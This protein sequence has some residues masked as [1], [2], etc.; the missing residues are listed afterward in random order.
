MAREG[1]VLGVDLLVVDWPVRNTEPPRLILRRRGPLR[2]WIAEPSL[3]QPSGVRLGLLRALILP[4][5]FL[6][7]RA[8]GEKLHGPQRI[9]HRGVFVKPDHRTRRPR[10]ALVHSWRDTWIA[11]IR[12]EPRP[13]RGGDAALL[14]RGV[15]VEPVVPL[16]LTSRRRGRGS[17]PSRFMGRSRTR[18]HRSSRSRTRRH[19]CVV[20]AGPWRVPLALP[21][22]ASAPRSRSSRRAWC[23]TGSSFAARVGRAPPCPRV[24]CADGG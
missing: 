8:L 24:V 15:V 16:I 12:D 2:R 13:G 3:L 6:P 19:S 21:F 23:P 20:P 17:R 11:A 10:P 14:L 18:V 4:P 5:L 1:V 7:R 22:G 9:L